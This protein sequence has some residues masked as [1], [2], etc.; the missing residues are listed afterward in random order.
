MSRERPRFLDGPASTDAGPA[1]PAPAPEASPLPLRPRLLDADPDASPGMGGEPAPSVDPSARAPEHPDLPPRPRLLDAQPDAPDAID[2]AWQPGAVAGAP[3]AA[4]GW[5]WLALGAGLLVA[6]LAAVSAEDALLSIAA[7]SA[8][9]ATAT[10]LLLGASVSL[11]LYGLAAEWRS[12]RRLRSVDG[13]RAALAARTASLEATRA[14]ALAWLARVAVQVPEAA[15]V[16][17]AIDAASTRVEL[18]SILENRIASPLRQAAQAA[19]QRAAAQA[20]GL[21]AI[22]PH[23]SWDGLIAG[24]RALALIR[25]VA[26][27]FGMRPGPAVTLFLMRKVAWTAAGTAGVDLMAMT[28]ADQALTNLPVV[29][30]LA[31][32]LPGAGVAALRLYRLA[33]LTA[34]AC[35]PVA[36]QAKR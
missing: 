13:L 5:S 2:P 14:L 36:L 15:A 1:A 20:A 35:C 18:Q 24:L 3:T 30:H 6:G 11:F 4:G 28:L 34:E 9:L 17:Q 7:R 31:A 23:A 21:I 16:E 33:G 8:F 29:R 19:G 26:G 22:S 12:Y 32:S 10:G 27:I 25:T